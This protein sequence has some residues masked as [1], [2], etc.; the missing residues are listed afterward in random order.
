[1]SLEETFNMQYKLTKQ[2]IT[3]HM[4]CVNLI[5]LKKEIFTWLREEKQAKRESKMTTKTLN[6]NKT[7]NHIRNANGY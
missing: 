2:P 1:M 6:L 5:A 4:N 3:N 7:R